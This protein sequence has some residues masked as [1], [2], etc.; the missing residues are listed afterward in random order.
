MLNK[1]GYEN[2]LIRRFKILGKSNLKQNLSKVRSRGI[3]ERTRLYIEVWV[4][5]V[6]TKKLINCKAFHNR[7][8]ASITPE[9]MAWT[10]WFRRS[11]DKCV[12]WN[13]DFLWKFEFLPIKNTTRGVTL[14]EIPLWWGLCSGGSIIAGGANIASLFKNIWR[15]FS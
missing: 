4:F 5:H 10:D 3:L 9:I 12:F 1:I 11:R 13:D 6:L 14:W 7:I 2:L 8:G 15:Y